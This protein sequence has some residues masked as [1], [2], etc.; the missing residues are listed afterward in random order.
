MSNDS[1]MTFKARWTAGRKWLAGAI[2]AG[3]LLGVAHA[4]QADVLIG[5]V[6]RVIDGDTILVDNPNGPR[7]S[8][9]IAG[10][11]APEPAQPYGRESR[12][13]L[14]RLVSVGD[15]RADCPKLDHRTSVVCK[16]SAYPTDCPTCGRT[17]DV[18]MAQIMA[19]MAWWYR[20]YEFEQSP[21]ERNL[22]EAAEKTARD[23]GRGLW[24][25]QK[26]VA[27]WEWRRER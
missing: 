24:A 9:R 1:D 19:G 21:K 25:D 7:Q 6:I 5:R 13:Y 10:I 3:T 8:V 27:P 23:N 15:V 22:Y 20:R 26:P 11:D 17:I 12:E 2:L 4:A 14:S 18:G 16:V